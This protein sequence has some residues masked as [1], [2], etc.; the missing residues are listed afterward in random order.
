MDFTPTPASRGGT[1]GRGPGLATR[2]LMRNSTT[3][4]N[5]SSST[6]AG[7]GSS[8]SIGN[9]GGTATKRDSQAAELERGA[10]SSKR[11]HMPLAPPP[12]PK[13]ATKALNTTLSAASLSRQLLTLQTAQIELE[14]KLRERDTTIERLERDRRWLAEREEEERVGR[15]KDRVA[16]G[17][18]KATLQQ[19][20]RT[21]RTSISALNEQHADLEDVHSALV[22]SSTQASS[23]SQAQT[24]ELEH[25]VRMLEGEV[26]EGKRL[27]DER[28]AAL[29]RMEEMLTLG[30]EGGC[31]H[32]QC[33]SHDQ[34]D[35][36][37]HEVPDE[38]AHEGDVDMEETR[39]LSASL[40]GRPSLSSHSSS[41]RRSLARRSQTPDQADSRR[42]D[43][44]LILSELTRQTAH[45]HNLESTN[46]RLSSEL[47]VLRG[48]EKVVGVLE[49][50]LMGLKG[51]VGRLEGAL[52]EREREIERL[53][54]E[55]SGSGSNANAGAFGGMATP[56]QTP[57]RNST[58]APS[59]STTPSIK[60]TNALATLRLTH[61]QLLAQHGVLKS[62]LVTAQAQLSGLEEA[63]EEA[64]ARVAE[65]EG[66]LKNEREGG[67]SEG[68]KGWWEARWRREK[69]GREKAEGEGRFL[70]GLVASYTAEAQQSHS[71]RQTTPAPGAGNIDDL[72]AQHVKHLETL[73][74]EY[75]STNEELA[76]RL[77]EVGGAAVASASNVGKQE[78]KKAK[79]DREE[80]L[81]EMEERLRDSQNEITTHL[82]RVDALEQQLF[83]LQGEIAGGR[84]VPPGVRVLQLRDN[85]ESQWVELRQAALDRLRNENEALMRRLK[86]VEEARGANSVS[87]SV[88]SQPSQAPAAEGDLVPRASWDL[89]SREKSELEELLRQKDKR[90]MR[91]KEVY[92]AKGAEFRDAIASV[93]GV[94]LSFKPNGQVRVTSVYDLCASFV[95][96]PASNA[97][98]GG[99]NGGGQEMRMQLVAQGD[100]GPQDL[101]NLMQF[102][103]GQEQC[104]PGFMASVTLECYDN[105]KRAGEVDGEA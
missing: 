60:E 88:A 43:N 67:G 44:A 97:N 18:E 17:D 87:G 34:E 25:R 45:L 102:W 86:E 99:S 90:L 40:S 7:A 27:A 83:E 48:R 100:G 58:Y 80:K 49:E 1:N 47:V 75:R 68:T 12:Y 23:R 103:I 82:E 11:L 77:D 24:R 63:L 42:L 52:A 56:Q 62:E 30:G 4:T 19:T 36:E 101:P 10:P 22:L 21:L 74:D 33:P 72:H 31:A 71:S 89:L 26:D 93:L 70:R 84:H 53:K 104:I 57:T 95:F 9:T 35:G 61:A 59:A 16:W 69:E 55:G 38:E 85:P 28:G 94:K 50:E 51:K 65:L 32:P 96:Q 79:E 15:E 20:L 92:N 81:R 98:G 29:S 8:G 41:H 66:D 91:L 6:P 5:G 14:A 3:A 105:A 54:E 13:S 37:A 39:P 2:M 76:Q 46:T 78:E 73:V 64:E